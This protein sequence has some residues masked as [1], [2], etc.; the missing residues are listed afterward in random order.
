[1]HVTYFRSSSLSTFTNYCE[2]KY[3]IIYNLGIQDDTN[4][5]TEKGTLCHAVMECLSGLKQ[6]YDL[7][8]KYEWTHEKLGKL[9][10]TKEQMEKPYK[11]SI[12]E[13]ERINKSR[14][15]KRIF[16]ECPRV[17]FGEIKYGV[18]AVSDIIKK[19]Y[20]YYSSKSNHSFKEED[21]NHCKN[22]CWLI[23]EYAN[24]NYDP[25]NRTIVSPE[26]PFNIVINEKWAEYDYLIGEK[27]IK[28]KLAIKGT[29]DLVTKIDEDTIEIIDYKFGQRY[30]W[31]KGIRKDYEVLMND[32][33]LMLYYYAARK[34]YPQYKNIIITIIFARDGG[35]FTLDF[36]DSVIPKVEKNLK[37]TFYKVKNTKMPKLLDYTHQDFRCNKLCKFFK[38]KVNEKSF[39]S[40][41]GREISSKGIDA[42]ELEYKKEGFYL[43]Y[44]QNPGE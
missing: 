27:K 11:L 3:Y 2:M 15:D 42:V 8:G 24:G 17:P 21:F 44:Y 28:G 4:I 18:E 30:D 6:S 41:I 5:K 1:M 29:I 35:P 31:G 14:L 23:T 33:Q 20:N 19:S 7:T 36:D 37:D 40:H 26:A 12:E 16:M 39:C 9:Y 34:V 43:T 25:R 32:E 13:V 22:W 38:Q 10:Y